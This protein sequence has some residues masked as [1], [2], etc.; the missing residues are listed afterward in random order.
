LPCLNELAPRM[1]FN[2]WRIFRRERQPLTLLYQRRKHSLDVKLVTH[3]RTENVPV[4]GESRYWRNRSYYMKQ[5]TRLFLRARHVRKP[6]TACA[7]R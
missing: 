3:S 1:P 5:G 6:L 4:H 2:C 7:A